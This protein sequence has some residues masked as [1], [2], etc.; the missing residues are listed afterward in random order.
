MALDDVLARLKEER[1]RLQAE[2]RRVV[3]MIRAA[4]KGAQAAVEEY[5]RQR[6][7][8]RRRANVAAPLK[9]VRQLSQATI[10]KMKKAQRDRRKREREKV[11]AEAKAVQVSSKKHLGKTGSSSNG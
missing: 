9:K 6:T 1:A 10:A 4:G 8:A 3:R 2:L 7:R 5:G 11:N